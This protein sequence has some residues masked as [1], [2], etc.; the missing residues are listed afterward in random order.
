M[1][2][3]F[4]FW[5]GGLRARRGRYW[6]APLGFVFSALNIFRPSSHFLMLW[7]LTVFF[8]A[9]KMMRLILLTG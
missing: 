6:V 2:T 4:F 3:S 8:F 7:A 5:G 9:N 1:R